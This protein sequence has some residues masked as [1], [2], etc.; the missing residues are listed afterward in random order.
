LPVLNGQLSKPTMP[1]DRHN[2]DNQLHAGGWLPLGLFLLLLCGGLYVRWP[3]SPQPFLWLD[4]AWRALGAIEAGAVQI[5]LPSEIALGRLGVALFGRTSEAMRI[6]PLLFSGVALLATYAFVSRAC[7]RWVALAAVSLIA[8]GPGFVFYAREFKPYSLDL[9]LTVSALWLAI[10]YRDDLTRSSLLALTAGLVVF[11]GSSLAFTFVYPAVCVFALLVTPL[12]KRQQIW[13]LLIPAAVFSVFYVGYLRPQS[14]STQ[15]TTFDYW[16][17]HFLTDLPSAVRLTKVGVR[18]LSNFVVVGPLCAAAAYLLALP[19][20]A[21]TRADRVAL[22]LGLPFVVQLIFSALGFYPLFGRPSYY[23]YGL[24]AIAVPYAVHEGVEWL[25]PDREG[26]QVF[27]SVALAV[28]ILVAVV[29]SR[30][31]LEAAMAWPNPQGRAVF[32]ALAASYRE[33]DTVY[34]NYGAFYP[35]RYHGLPPARGGMPYSIGTPSFFEGIQDQSIAG[36][37]RSLVERCQ[38]HK[39]G[40][41]LWFVSTHVPFAYR[42]YE[43]LLPDVAD[44][45]V[46]IAQR[47]QSL[48]RV[49]L[50]KFLR[51]LD[52]PSER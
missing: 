50:H 44:V 15:A 46:V 18:D 41:R 9:A 35:V 37:C 29:G 49:D 2:D 43:A 13:V 25:W 1:I 16:G 19:V 4:E 21:L 32:S 6:W 17:D 26:R 20:L 5:L 12:E 45:K 36:L 11:A 24:V 47:R 39:K 3:A 10:R 42:S 28:L 52:C 33:G 7:S 48:V 30:K 51:K 14:T 34:L 40:E 27:A 23:L 31:N 38:A 8:F 22:L